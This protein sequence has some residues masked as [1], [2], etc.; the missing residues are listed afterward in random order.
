MLSNSIGHVFDYYLG[1]E[2]Q[3][4]LKLLIKWFNPSKETVAEFKKLFSEED[5]PE[6]FYQLL[7]EIVQNQTNP[8]S[9]NIEEAEENLQS[10]L[11]IQDALAISTIGAGVIDNS[12]IM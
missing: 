12:D 9:N 6:N 2:M 8:V 7:D 10:N 3:D 4:E 5:C 1:E 11:E